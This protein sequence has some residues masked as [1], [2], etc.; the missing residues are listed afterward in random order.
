VKPVNFLWAAYLVTLLLH[1][2]Y[3]LVLARRRKRVRDK[4]R[5][6]ETGQNKT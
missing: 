2:G 1:V 3:L 4:L 5:A 6:M